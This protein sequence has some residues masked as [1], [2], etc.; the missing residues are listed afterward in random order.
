M[1]TQRLSMREQACLLAQMARWGVSALG[2][3]TRFPSPVPDNPK[4]MSPLAAVRL[5]HD[6]DVVAVSGIGGQ[7]RA[8]IVYCAIRRAFEQDGHPAD[9]TV[10]NL[11]GHGGRGMVSG[12]LEELARPGL[13]TRLITS[14]FEALPALLD[15]A[16][17]HHCE[18]QC[19]P[20][21]VMSLLFDALGR[22]QHSWLTD[23]GV[24][25]FIDPRVG[26]G[27][28][29]AGS[30]REQ[31]VTAA[32]RRLRYRIPDID[33]AV[34]NLPAADRHGNLYARDCATIGESLEIAR[35]ARRH[36]G[37][38]IANVGRI[39]DA[40]SDRV[41]LPAAMVDA[42]VYY[43]DTE[44]V[45]GFFHREPWSA[46]T[47]ASDTS[48]ADGLARVDFVNWLAGVTA[49]RTPADEVLARLAAATL[50]A[51]TRA[52]SYVDIGVGLPEELSRVLYEAG[53]LGHLTLCTESG[54]I[55][56]LPATGVYFG[57]AL[58]P[59]QIIS[60]AQFFKLCAHRLDATCL[61]VLQADSEGNVNVSKRGQGARRY[62][63][64]GGF[65]DLTAAA[66]TIIFV[67]A[68]MT[69]G[70]I[71]VENGALH[72][73][74]RGQPKFVHSVDEITYN[75]RRGLD[76][77]KRVFFATHVGLFQLTRSGMTLVR[78]MPGIDVQRDIIDATAMK[79]ILPRSGQVP[80]VPRSI[81]TGQ[82]LVLRGIGNGPAVHDK[83]RER[84]TAA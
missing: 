84:A 35:A 69:H 67:S 44:Q 39:V 32:G 25:T 43:P 1:N 23:V 17:R 24:G 54:V 42:V 14:H 10:M 73:V 49:R 13:C 46:L 36:H 58:C 62:V 72:I 52:G 74:R 28:C 45:P 82:S 6:G 31:L 34:F 41:F 15:L 66:K 21:G 48:I 27:S 22:G 26:P 77:G 79:V 20:L 63:G 57:A 83:P 11:G 56:G 8:S 3:D 18:L 70:D 19:I 37:R 30:A 76:A 59:Q 71:A 4:F 7:Q 16:A 53:R 60:S 47:T 68:W 38:V 50:L 2:R 75:G 29:V 61:G 81:V 12:T 33:V 40:G 5:I 9:L 65:I 78:V 51:S 80:L 64:P 55:G